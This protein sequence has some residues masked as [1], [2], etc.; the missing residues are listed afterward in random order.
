LAAPVKGK[1]RAKTPTPFE[2]GDIMF[3]NWRG[4]AKKM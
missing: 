2:I 3:Y 4:E 1:L